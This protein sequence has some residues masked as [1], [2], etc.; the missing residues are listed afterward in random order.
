MEIPKVIFSESLKGLRK[1]SIIL[2]L[3]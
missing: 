1:I 2:K 3:F